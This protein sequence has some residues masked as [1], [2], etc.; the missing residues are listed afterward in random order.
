MILKVGKLKRLRNQMSTTFVIH[1]DAGRR[2][3]YVFPVRRIKYFQSGV[4]YIVKIKVSLDIHESK[5]S[6]SLY[7][8]WKNYP[9]VYV[10]LPEKHLRKRMAY[11]SL[12]S[13]SWQL[14]GR[15]REYQKE[16]ESVYWLWHLDDSILL[17][18]EGPVTQV[19]SSSARARSRLVPQWVLLHWSCS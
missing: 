9:R 13:S 6:Q 18:R 8:I 16:T 7:S 19:H 12:Q 10:N 4:P 15:G 11:T 3:S 5:H 2:W 14:D 1:S 17:S